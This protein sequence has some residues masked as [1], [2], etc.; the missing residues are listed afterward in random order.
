MASSRN[1]IVIIFLHIYITIVLLELFYI[2]I[3]VTGKRYGTL[4][5]TLKFLMKDFKSSN[6]V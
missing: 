5:K 3:F 6:S 2:E 4:Q 1:D